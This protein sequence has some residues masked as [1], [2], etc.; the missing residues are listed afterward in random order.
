[1]GDFFLPIAALAI[2]LALP[3]VSANFEFGE[4][5]EMS[6]PFAAVRSGVAS[7]TAAAA[8]FARV[9]AG[10]KSDG[11]FLERRR[12]NVDGEQE[13]FELFNRGGGAVWGK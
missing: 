3:E 7:D 11:V 8:R 12:I 4:D 5:R 9:E 1:M 13:A 10:E 2:I 6:T